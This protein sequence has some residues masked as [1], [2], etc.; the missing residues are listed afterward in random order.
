MMAA[1]S[2]SGSAARRVLAAI[3]TA[4][5]A[6]NCRRVGIVFIPQDPAARWSLALPS[7]CPG[8]FVTTLFVT[9]DGRRL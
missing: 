6:S 2:F 8:V 5:L 9:G 4:V 3:A 7:L 1:R